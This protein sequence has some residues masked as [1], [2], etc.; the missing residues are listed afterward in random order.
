MKLSNTLK[1]A[2]V[3]LGA[4]GAAGTA[5]AADDPTSGRLGQREYQKCVN[6]SKTVLQAAL[7]QSG[8]DRNKINSAYAHY[9][10]NVARCRARFL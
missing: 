9:R 2:V 4:F 3:M 10:G 1:I 7:S 6:F 8:G 5:T